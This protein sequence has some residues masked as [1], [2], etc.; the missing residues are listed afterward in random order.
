MYKLNN[1]CAVSWKNI[2]GYEQYQ[3]NN[4][5][6]IKRN[7]KILKPIKSRNGYLHI[8]LYSNGKAKQMLVHRI[9]AKAFIENKNNLEEINHKD[10]NKENNSVNN[11]EWCTRKQNV[12][13]FFYTNQQNDNKPKSVIQYDLSGRKINEFSS[14]RKASKETKVSAHNI[15]YCCRGEK[16]TA[17]NYI[18]CYKTA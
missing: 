16:P 8:F 9:V 6:Q 11:L 14:I 1:A 17:S 13:H 12:Q 3:V 15:I 5:G 10:G 4:L 2:K 18:W 7:N